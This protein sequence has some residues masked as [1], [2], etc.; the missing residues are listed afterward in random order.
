MV[1]AESN[2]WA[3]MFDT[4]LPY[5]VIAA[6]LLG[7]VVLV[8]WAIREGISGARDRSLVKGRKP[9][10]PPGLGCNDTSGVSQVC[11]RLSAQNV[12]DPDERIKLDAAWAEF[13]GASPA[14]ATRKLRKYE[15]TRDEIFAAAW[16]RTAIAM[17][18]DD[19]AKRLLPAESVVVPSATP[20]GRKKKEKVFG[21]VDDRLRDY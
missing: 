5:L 7:L 11:R 13:H 15:A 20:N 4:G 16:T 19:G 14:S 18:D 6:V 1:S 9:C 12:A 21:E 17:G 8:I 10:C 3:W 2:V